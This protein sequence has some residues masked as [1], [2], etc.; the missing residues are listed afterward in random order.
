MSKGLYDKYT[1]VKNDGSIT[2]SDADYFVL[3][4]DTDPH[5]RI[6]ALAYA[7]SVKA[8]NPNLAFD[9]FQRVSKIDKG[10]IYGKFD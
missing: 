10:Q 1:V 9:I 6:A 7:D 2:D 8:E 5:A 3:R 4:L